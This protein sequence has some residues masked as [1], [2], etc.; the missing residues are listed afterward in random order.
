MG[1]FLLADGPGDSP[2][3]PVASAA[4]P[5]IT[6]CRSSDR[7]IGCA[8]PTSE[9]QLMFKTTGA[10]KRR[11]ASGHRK[12]AA[13]GVVGSAFPYSTTRWL[14]SASHIECVHVPGAPSDCTT[15]HKTT[16]TEPPGEREAGAPERKRLAARPHSVKVVWECLGRTL[17]IID[18]D[19]TWVQCNKRKAH[20]HPA[21][22]SRLSVQ[23]LC[24]GA[25]VRAESAL[26][27]RAL[28]RKCHV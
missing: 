27:I 7:T 22:S 25:G 11:S 14:I 26:V 20:R 8:V 3:A 12:L 18:G 10:T 28:A 13:R 19:T 17:W 5:E 4:R 9:K 2:D 23:T 6:A 15:T 21:Q 24:L 1:S 16:H